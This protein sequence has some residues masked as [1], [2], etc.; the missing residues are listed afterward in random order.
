MKRS[1]LLTNIIAVLLFLTFAAYLLAHA[2]QPENG[3]T[4]AQAMT[5]EFQT[6]GSASGI[7][8]REEIV[9]SS[10]E[11]YIDIAVPDGSRV[12]AGTL[13]GNTMSSETGL[14]R[15]NRI[16]EL[17]SE[18]ARISAALETMNSAEDLT[19]R[20]ETLNRAVGDMAAAVAAHDLDSLG[21]SSLSIRS[22]LFHD[23]GDSASPETLQALKT[24]L[25]SLQG[26]SSSDTQPIF[27]QQS[28]TFS[29][30]LDGYEHISPTSLT[31]LTPSGLQELMDSQAGISSGAYGKLVTDYRW[32]FAAVMSA[33]DAGNLKTG[34][35]ATLN[36]G[37]FYGSDVYARVVS[38]SAPEGENVAVVFRCDTALADTIGMRQAT[39][40]VVF[41]EYSGI[42][43][44]SQA[45]QV[46]AEEEKTF[47]WTV[48]AMQLERKDVNII[49][50]GDSFVIVSRDA[51]ADALREGNTV[52]VSGKNL[53]EGKVVG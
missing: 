14:E 23:Y 21:A 52:V 30:M 3:L 31:R 32:Y 9:L 33:K 26:S 25:S 51:D 15:S 29:S 17:E 40:S 47:V 34:R 18:I 53:Y 20:N 11:K 28:G 2:W 8:V 46:D 45:I 6:G 35:T 24:E 37:R 49:Y 13:I 7:V 16:H 22:L 5:A 48:T 1:D 42:R 10:T 27:V 44:P 39:A 19:G 43:I 50:A 4:T 12:A 41:E 36:F 38:I